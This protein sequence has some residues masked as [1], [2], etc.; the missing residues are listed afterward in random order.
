MGDHNGQ[1]FQV[2]IEGALYDWNGDTITVPEI[3]QLGNLPSNMPVI[4]V[5]LKDNTERTLAETETVEIKPGMGF[6]KKVGFKRGSE[7]RIR[8]ELAMLRGGWPDL[9]YVPEGHWVRIPRYVTSKDIWMFTEPEVCFQIP[10][11]L[12]GQNPYAFY[13]RPHMLLTGGGIPGSYTFPADSTPFGT[14]WGRFSWQL[15][16]WQ[17]HADVAKGSNM[18]N[19]V[20]SFA[21]RFRQ[22]Q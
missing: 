10:A 6:G 9:Q 22:G 2:N 16:P 7:D 3:R 17:P 21:D 14:G 15:E 12:P 8:Q 18:V 13:V 4:E 20:L 1:K 11:G 5:D 19:F